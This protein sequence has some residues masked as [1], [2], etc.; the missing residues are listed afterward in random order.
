MEEPGHESVEKEDQTQETSTPKQGA[1][2]WY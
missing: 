1:D 2:N